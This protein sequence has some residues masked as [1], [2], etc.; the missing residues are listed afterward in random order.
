[1]RHGGRRLHADRRKGGNMKLTTR[2]LPSGRWRGASLLVAAG[3]LLPGAVP[4][5]AGDG[6]IVVTPTARTAARPELTSDQL[7]KLPPAP[8][9]RPPAPP[10]SGV[11][12]RADP[13]PP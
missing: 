7:E 8:L 6:T 3:L 4:V 13:G 10:I 2:T 12:P 1:M 9:Y 5:L 11:D